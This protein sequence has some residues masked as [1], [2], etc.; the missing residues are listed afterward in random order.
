MSLK[1]TGKAS[2]AAGSL[3]WNRRLRPIGGSGLTGSSN[4][5][6]LMGFN[7]RVR[8]KSLLG[9]PKITLQTTHQRAMEDRA[10][11]WIGFPIPVYPPDLTISRVSLSVT[12]QSLTRSVSL[13]LCSRLSLSRSNR[14]K[15]RRTERRRKKTKRK[16]KEIKRTG[17]F[18][19]N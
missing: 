7:A 12:S 11:G 10:S 9:T 6:G 15:K 3:P 16:E 2:Q 18:F 13:S 4:P 19:F 5:L 14:K 17:S 1:T 8:R